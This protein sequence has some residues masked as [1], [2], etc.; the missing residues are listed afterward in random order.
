ML[1]R[2]GIKVFLCSC[3]VIIQIY[4]LDNCLFLE[5]ELPLQDGVYN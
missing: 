3:F 1:H 4:A 2:E 5:E